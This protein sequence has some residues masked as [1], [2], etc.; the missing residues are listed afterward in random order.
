MLTLVHQRFS[1][2]ERGSSWNLSGALVLSRMLRM[3]VKGAC[4]AMGLM[5]T[6]K[7]SWK[8]DEPLVCVE[9]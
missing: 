6:I 8:V 1:P 9:V 4:R 2:G 5:V 7:G 3:V